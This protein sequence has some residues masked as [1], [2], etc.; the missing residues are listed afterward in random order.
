M[1][2]LDINNPNHQLDYFPN[3]ILKEQETIVLKLIDNL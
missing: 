1:V 2:Y 3:P